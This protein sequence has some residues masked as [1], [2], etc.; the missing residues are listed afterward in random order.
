MHASSR[1][2]ARRRRAAAGDRGRCGRRAGRGRAGR[3]AQSCA[4]AATS[5][6]WRWSARTMPRR[7]A[8]TAAL[9]GRSRAGAADRVRPLPAARAHACASSRSTS[10]DDSPVPWGQT[11]R[12][13]DVGGAAVRA[14]RRDAG[15]A[16]RGLDRGARAVAPVPPLPGPRRPLAVGGPGELLPERAARPRRAADAGRRRGASSMPA[17]DAAGASHSGMP[18]DRTQPGHR[19]T[20]R[21]YWAGAAFWLEADLALRREHRSSLDRGAVAVFALLPARH[22]RG[23]AGGVPGRARR[24]RRRRRC[25][26]PLYERYAQSREFPSLDAAYSA[27]G[28]CSATRTAWTSP[29]GPTRRRLR[30]AIMRP[31][32]KRSSEPAVPLAT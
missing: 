19:G 12:R 17:S 9:A 32:A 4:P 27:L 11:L 5:C 10:D 14:R 31:R 23:R 6:A 13:D 29:T 3:D 20:M 18:L 1:A 22:R 7:R 25:S 21:V 8:R 30:A 2:A 28:I 16:A 24:A 26:S 15:R